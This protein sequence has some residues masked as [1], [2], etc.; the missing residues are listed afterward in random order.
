MYTV[1]RYKTS[2]F[3][4]WNQFITTAKNAT[5]LFH[6]NFMEYHKD[7]FEDY[8][9]IICKANTIVALLPA[10]ISDNQIHSHQGLTYGGLLL[11]SNVGVSKVE[12]IFEEILTYFKKENIR[13]L[14]LKTVPFLYHK[15]SAYDLEPIFFKKQAPIIKRNQGFYINYNLP[16][17]IHKTKLK[18]FRKG[19]SFNF[20][21]TKNSNFKDF[22]NE[23]LIP[24][25]QKKHGA[26]PVHTLQEIETL[27]EK[28]P[29]NIIQ[30][31][32]FKESELLAGITV[33][34]TDKVIKSQYG[35]TSDNGEKYRALDYLFIHVIEAYKKKG[36]DYFDMGVINNNYSLLK[37]KE[38]LGGSQYIQDVY[39][40]KLA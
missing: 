25:L 38:E 20:I 12:A 2:D 9:L 30:Y 29:D 22:W 16:L 24:R 13:F 21:I 37:Q 6:R 23:I 26:K 27:A 17:S 39:Q 11:P 8:S 36:Y 14:T 33:F 1:K 7:R 31:C 10:N 34:K 40:L 28:F 18:N 32:I 35:A 4:E 5:F 19:E 3:N 15:N